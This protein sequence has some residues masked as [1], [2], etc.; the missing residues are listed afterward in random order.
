MKRKDTAKKMEAKSCLN[1]SDW[2][3]FLSSER[4]AM[5]SN[6][7]TFS[8]FLVAVIALILVTSGHIAFA[9]ASGIIAFGCAGWVY[10]GALEPL[11][12]RGKLAD[13][14]LKGIISGELKD[15]DSI[16]QGWLLGL[17]VIRRGWFRQE[18][19]RLAVL[20]RAW[21]PQ[22]KATLATVKETWRPRWEMGLATL[23]ETWYRQRARLAALKETWG[24]RWEAESATLKETWCRQRIR[25]AVLKKTWRPRWER[26][27]SALK[28][29]WCQGKARL[30]TLKETWRRQWEGGI[31]YSQASVAPVGSGTSYSRGNSVPR[32]KSKHVRAPSRRKKSA[33]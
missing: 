14:I 3:A 22:W 6:A 30:A 29:T 18:K 7:V 19:A 28:E 21:R 16:R 26:G 32:N 27:I 17:T 8:V 4:Q 33:A 13:E 12:Q 10:F 20:K 2:V 1:I 24:P 23:K 5:M 25:L 31:S 9:I 11:R 15:A